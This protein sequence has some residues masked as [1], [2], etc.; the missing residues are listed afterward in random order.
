MQIMK[1]KNIASLLLVGALAAAPLAVNAANSQSNSHQHMHSK[2]VKF[3][4]AKHSGFMQGKH[5]AKLNLSQEQKDQLFQ[6]RHEKAV[7]FY[8]QRKA[9]KAASKQ[10][11]ELAQA[12]KFD[13]DKA[14]Q[15]SNELGQA[16]ASLAL[17]K[18]Q[19]KADFMAIL[20]PEQKQIL[21]DSKTKK[22]ASK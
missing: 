19:S 13:A 11:R 14:K 18:A 10:L 7:E 16:Q 21:A 9:V 8:E 22:A 12:D 17:L 5:M 1:I 6:K 15:L 3:A 2:H 20:S 4:K